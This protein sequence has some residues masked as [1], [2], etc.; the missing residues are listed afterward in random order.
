LIP[1]SKEQLRLT[2]GR[3]A[4]KLGFRMPGFLARDMRVCQPFEASQPLLVL[5]G[6]IVSIATHQA[7]GMTRSDGL[8]Q[9]QRTV[10]PYHGRCRTARNRRHPSSPC[11]V[12][13]WRR[14][15]VAASPVGGRRLRRRSDARQRRCAGACASGATRPRAQP[16]PNA[17]SRVRRSM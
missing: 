16:G 14:R 7:H 15:H 11:G 13:R 12:L 6:W 4:F 8:S 9:W 1:D 10:S 3:I 17:G 2:P 5:Y